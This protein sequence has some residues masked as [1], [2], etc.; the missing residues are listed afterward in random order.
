MYERHADPIDEAAALEASIT[1]SAIAAA[2]QSSAPEMHP[3]FDGETCV[4]CGDFI[5][6]ARLALMK[7]RCVVCQSRLEK[8]RAQ[9]R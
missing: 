3:D 5:P 9:A 1:E 6:P 4:S 2:R 8:Q 7:I